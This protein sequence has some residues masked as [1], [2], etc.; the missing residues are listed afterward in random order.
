MKNVYFDNAATTKVDDEVLE[1]MIPYYKI[2]YGN[3]SSIHQLGKASKVLIEDTRDLIADFIG[4]KSKEIFFTSSGTEAINFAL[5]GSAF[6]S[7]SSEKNHIIISETEH[8]AVLNTV[9][10]LKEK[11]SF[12][13]TFIKPDKNGLI[14]VTDVTNS[15]TEKTFL[16]SL[17]HSNNE[18]GNITDINAISE[19]IHNKEILFL[20]DTIQS[21]GKMNL[22]VQDMRVNFATMS[23]HKIYG[24]KGIAAIFINEKTKV[25]KFIHGGMQERNMRGGT[26][27]IPAIAGFNKSVEMLKKKMDEDIQHYSSLKNYLWQKLEVEFQDEIIFNTNK[28][29]SLPNILNFSPDP[30]KLNFDEEM[31]LIQLDLKGIAV[32]GGSACTSGT[33]QPSHVITALGRDPR[34]SLAAIRVSF[35]RD[36]STDEVDYFIESLKAI[37]KKN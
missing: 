2:Y 14:N 25:D 16:I 19:V 28:E 31:L 9:N 6:H 8:S 22:N 37:V 33:N 27:N 1:A 10:Y 35:G 11:F 3:A 12:D 15:I 17:M 26:E 4:V 23:A 13:V 24:P 5:K 20:A 34:T 36:N 18:T 21:I 7:F 32:S 30:E 29:N